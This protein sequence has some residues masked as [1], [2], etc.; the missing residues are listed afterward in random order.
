MVRDKLREKILN[1]VVTIKCG[2][3]DKYGRLLIDIKERGALTNE[4][5]SEWLVKNK[6]A[7]EYDGGTKKD[8]SVYLTTISAALEFKKAGSQ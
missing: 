7:F 8:W 1:K 5:I 6:Y 3:F 4:T 2:D